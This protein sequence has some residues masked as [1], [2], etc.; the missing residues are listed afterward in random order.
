M[1]TIITKK[2]STKAERVFA[3]LL[4]DSHIPFQHRVLINEREVDFIVGKYAIDID[5][6]DQDSE[7]NEMLVESGYIPIHLNNRE[8]M[9]NKN[10]VRSIIK[11]L[12]EYN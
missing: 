8:V 10:L 5:G 9:S 7:K 3:E 2:N 12:H 4:K 11:Q 6:H 1:R